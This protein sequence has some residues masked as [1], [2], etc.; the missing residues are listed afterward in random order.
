MSWASK[1]LLV[2]VIGLGLLLIRAPGAAASTSACKGAPPSIGA[3]VHGPVLDVVD[4]ETLCV[5]LGPTPDRWVALKLAD[6]PN[7]APTNGADRARGALMAVAFARNVDCRV[8][9]ADK[10]GRSAVCV[11]DGR[12]IVARMREHD[13]VSVGLAWR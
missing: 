5:A 10:A 3:A 13:A 1:P 12:S 6:A 9:A 8:V 11:L 2:I 4:G 7:A